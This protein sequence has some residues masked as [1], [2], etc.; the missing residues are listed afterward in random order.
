MC[1]RSLSLAR[2]LPTL[3]TLLLAALAAGCGD[4]G[5]GK[6]YPVRGKVTFHDEPFTAG[7]TTVVF[8]PIA[9]KGNTTPF[10][11]MA[12]VDDEGNYSLSTKGQRGAPPGWYKVLVAAVGTAPPSSAA[13]PKKFKPTPP[14]LLPTKYGRTETTPLEIE[15]VE[16]PAPGAYDLKLTK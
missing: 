11:P 14:S 7:T 10:E 2:A 15:V 13:K 8:K 6:T 9:A 16:S 5:V 4:G 1:Y 3:A 12:N